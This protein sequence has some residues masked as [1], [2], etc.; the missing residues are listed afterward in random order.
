MPG[1]GCLDLHPDLN[2][3]NLASSCLKKGNE[4]CG[5]LAKFRRDCAIECGDDQHLVV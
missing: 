1:R 5:H 2:S 4:L 3:S